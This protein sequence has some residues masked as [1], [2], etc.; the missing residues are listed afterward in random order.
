MTSRKLIGFAPSACRMLLF[1][2]ILAWSF[3]ENTT[4][5]IKSDIAQ[6][7]AR[8][9]VAVGRADA[10]LGRSNFGPAFAQLALFVE[11][12]V[13]RQNEMRAV[14]DE[15]IFADCDVHFPQAFDLGDE[16]ERIDNDA[17]ADHA[18]FAA[19]KNSRRDQV[20]NVFRSADE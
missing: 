2:C 5:C 18:D 7:G 14:A 10:A 20:Q 4:G 19:S 17:V 3:F 6:T 1:S 13:I 12:A 8:G 11:Q 15:Q 9:F 16:R